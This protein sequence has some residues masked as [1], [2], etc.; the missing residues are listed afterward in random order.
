MTYPGSPGGESGVTRR[1]EQPHPKAGH[2]HTGRHG[3]DRRL[4]A[5]QRI[6]R[7]GLR[8]QCRTFA[9]RGSLLDIFSYSNELPYRVDFFGDEIDSI[10]TFNI[11]TQLSEQKM[12][13]VAV[14]SMSAGRA[15]STSLLGFIGKDTLLAV[16]DASYTVGR[17]RAIAGESISQSSLIA[18]EKAIPMLWPRWWTGSL[19]SRLCIVQMPGIQRR[20]ATRR[21]KS[22]VNRLQSFATGHIPQNFDL[23]SESF[24]RLEADGY[25]LYILSDSTKQIERLRTIFADRGDNIGFTPVIS[26][27]HEGFL[28]HQTR[29]ACS[30]TTRYST[31][32]INIP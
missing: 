2:R 20:H 25:T 11:E 24:K 28:D 31:V 5:R 32:S 9:I 29:N 22:N 6:P 10:R 13:S 8:I 17:I 26:T 14:T 3:S 18:D 21:L 12:Q 19:R 16:R 30:Q 27:L 15:G 23:I 7:S 1:H 4:A